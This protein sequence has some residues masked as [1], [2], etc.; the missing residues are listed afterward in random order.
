[1]LFKK[2]FINFYA[3]LNINIFNAYTHKELNR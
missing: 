1:M 2:I 3:W